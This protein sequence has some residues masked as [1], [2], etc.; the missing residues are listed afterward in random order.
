M[1]DDQNWAIVREVV[2]EKR[3]TAIVRRYFEGGWDARLLADECTAEHVAELRA[4]FPDL[5][6]TITDLAARGDL[7][8]GRFTWQGTQQ[9]VFHTRVGIFLPSGQRATWTVL[10]VFLV[11]ERRLIAVQANWDLLVLGLLHQLSA[12]VDAAGS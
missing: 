6:V 9:G 2:Q 7:V 8:S 3:N 10:A 1:P 4:A 12:N 11:V 5:R